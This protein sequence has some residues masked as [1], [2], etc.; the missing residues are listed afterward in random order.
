[1]ASFPVKNYTTKTPPSLFCGVNCKWVKRYESCYPKNTQI[2]L[3][4]HVLRV[5]Q[6]H[7]INLKRPKKNQTKIQKKHPI[8]KDI[9]YPQNRLHQNN[10]EIPT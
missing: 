3:A 10:S 2:N 6:V 9:I 8:K 4:P 7:F 1:L 5:A